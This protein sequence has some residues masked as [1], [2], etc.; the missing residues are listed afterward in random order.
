LYQKDIEV[1][2][3]IHVYPARARSPKT[4]QNQTAQSLNAFDHDVAGMQFSKD[5][6]EKILARKKTQTRRPIEK[7]RGVG[8]CEV[9][10]RVAVQICRR[11]AAAHIIIKN[12]RK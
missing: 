7:K 9:G 2:S 5:M 12:R 8:I 11:A 6:A 3:A 10:D 4:L 1:S